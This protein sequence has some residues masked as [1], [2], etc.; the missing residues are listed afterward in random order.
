MNFPNPVQTFWDRLIQDG[1][2]A[3]NQ[4]YWS[5]RIG[6]LKVVFLLYF[7]FAMLLLL[8]SIPDCCFSSDVPVSQLNFHLLSTDPK[9]TDWAVFGFYL[10]PLQLFRTNHYLFSV[11]KLVI[12]WSILTLT[13]QI[14]LS[15]IPAILF[16]ISL[17]FAPFNQYKITKK[18]IAFKLKTFF[19][20]GRFRAKRTVVFYDGECL[21]CNGFITRLSNLNLPS[22]LYFASQS[23]STFQEMLLRF[24]DVKHLDAILI[25]EEHE[26]R[27]RILIKTN[28]VLQ[29]LAKLNKLYFIPLI[30][31]EISP[32]FAD[33]IYDFI[34]VNRKK[35]E[36]GACPI[37]PMAVR[38]RLLF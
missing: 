17:L 7:A 23:S 3:F 6:T 29:L 21:M 19:N 15:V 26:E 33:L 30:I 32:Y 34:A 14:G 31:R 35:A 37:P 16:S 8:K 36:N 5:Y 27:E 4:G 2:H 22:S 11:P 18:D 12:L 38:E 24:P 13:N 20:M 10:L 25:L 9:V 1:K 28:G